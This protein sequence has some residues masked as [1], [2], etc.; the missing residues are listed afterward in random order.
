[1]PCSKNKWSVI[2]EVNTK[3]RKVE[4]CKRRKQWP[5][6][7][8]SGLVKFY[9]LNVYLVFSKSSGE[10]FCRLLEVSFFITPSSLELVHLQ[11]PQP[12]TLISVISVQYDHCALLGICLSALWSGN[13]LQD[14]TQD[15]CRV[16]LFHFSSFPGSAELPVV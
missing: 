9:P 6:L 15:N 10:P 11:P 12:Q 4:K 7:I 13:C 3:W 16:Y 5:C 2:F 1:M 8:V 14:E